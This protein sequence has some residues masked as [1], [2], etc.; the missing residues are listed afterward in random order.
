MQSLDEEVDREENLPPI[1]EVYWDE[2]KEFASEIREVIFEA[3]KTNKTVEYVSKNIIIISC[4]DKHVDG[5]LTIYEV[6]NREKDFILSYLS[7][8]GNPKLRQ[9]YLLNLINKAETYGINKEGDLKR[10]Y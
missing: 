7:F 1:K 9:S 4:I 2:G 5:D 6:I 3:S 10:A 8:I